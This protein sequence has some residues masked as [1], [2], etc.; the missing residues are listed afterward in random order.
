MDPARCTE[1][2]AVKNLRLAQRVEHAPPQLCFVSDNQVQI[3]SA[4]SRLPDR[5]GA[6]LLRD[7]HA[8]G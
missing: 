4:S 3:R 7:T 6:H 1:Q 8:A 2:T 5:S